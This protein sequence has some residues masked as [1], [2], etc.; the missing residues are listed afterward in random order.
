MRMKQ[1]TGNLIIGSNNVDNGDR[2]QVD[3]SINTNRHLILS[4]S[5]GWGPAI[6]STSTN[7][8]LEI[9]AGNFRSAYFNP[10]GTTHFEQRMWIG[11]DKLGL[12]NVMLAVSGGDILGDGRL[13]LGEQAD[14]GERLFVDGT[15]KFNGFLYVNNEAQIE[16]Q[17]T[18]GGV[19]KGDLDFKR[20]GGG[21]GANIKISPTSY[22][23][24]ITN[25]SGGGEQNANIRFQTDTTYPNRFI[26][27]KSDGVHFASVTGAGN[28]IIG[29]DSTDDLNRLQVQGNAKITGDLIV[30][31]SV[32]GL[33]KSMVGLNAVN[34]TADIDK[35]ISSATATAL[36]LKA[37]TSTLANYVDLTSA[38]TIAGVKSFSSNLIA[39][40]NVGIGY[41]G[42]E[43]QL[44][45]SSGDNLTTVGGSGGSI[46]RLTNTYATTYGSGGEIQF[47]IHNSSANS[48]VLSAIKGTYSQF[49][50]FYGGS[51]QFFTKNNTDGV[52]S[53][54]MVIRHDGN[55][56]IGTTNPGNKLH[57]T[58]SNAV[59]RFSG[60]TWFNIYNAPIIVG[61]LN[62]SGA[63]NFA[64][65]SDGSAYGFVGYSANNDSNE[66]RVSVGGGASYLTFHSGGT[67]GMRIAYNRNVLIGTNLT[68]SGEKLQVAGSIKATTSI[69]S[70]SGFFVKGTTTNVG[71][72]RSLSST[73]N[74]LLI[75]ADPSNVL[76]DSEIAFYVD[77][78]FMGTWRSGNLGV[79]TGNPT[80]KLD[81]NGTARIDGVLTTTTDAV[82]NGGV[83]G[84]N[85]VVTINST[86]K[87]F[88]L[89]RMTAAQG[90]AIVSPA[91]ALLIYVLDTNATFTSKGWWGY[92]GATWEKLNN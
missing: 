27:E 92:N 85:A 12:S 8:P 2:L 47:G 49:N 21:T 72:V 24:L 79:G 31:G 16:N 36:N 9:F 53:L 78:A 7:D 13:I 30:A 67:E 15:G 69:E 91:E 71:G 32:T 43:T 77:G 50:P 45:L 81:V 38:Q 34:N 80:Y 87:G 64:R 82:F 66:F 57:V 61:E 37:N 74:A 25:K 22:D 35:A 6:N 19:G 44:T 42:P 4:A 52:L 23:L 63:I 26:F 60:G 10:D 56:G 11:I 18:L 28:F 89:P 39:S 90:S 62:S 70:T 54:K 17:L 46:L 88:L 20:G 83:A 14:T 84:A 48:K 29:P 58:G 86:T 68:D 73:R 59:A 3:G 76:G 1:Q 40:G 33:T 55:V 65:S 75:E 51:L 5:G 41:S